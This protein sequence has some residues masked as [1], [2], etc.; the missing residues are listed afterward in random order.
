MIANEIIKKKSVSEL[1]KPKVTIFF[2][3]ISNIKNKNNPN[4]KIIKGILFPEKS[5]PVAK[6]HIIIIAMGYLV[7]LLFFNI[8]EAKSI[9][10]I[11]NLCMKFP[12]INSVPKKLELCDCRL[13]KPIIL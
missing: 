6:T 12:A 2:I 9:E 3:L 11:E 7:Y 5:I 1:I 4:K 13:F 10:K 8:S